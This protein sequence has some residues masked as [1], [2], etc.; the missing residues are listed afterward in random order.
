MISMKPIK[1]PDVIELLNNGRFDGDIDGYVIMNGPEFLGSCIFRVDGGNVTV[2]DA[3]T[4]GTDQT[5]PDYS[6]L[7][8]AVR[9]AVANGQNRGADN[10]TVLYTNSSLENWC[11]VFCGGEHENIPISRIFGHCEHEHENHENNAN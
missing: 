6:V 5:P 8:G 1:E 7:D 3:K 2:L 9:A 10:F 4:K 11:R